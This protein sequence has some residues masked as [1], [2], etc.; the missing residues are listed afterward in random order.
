MRRTVKFTKR[1]GNCLF[2]RMADRKG[3]KSYNTIEKSQRSIWR[4]WIRLE[5]L[6]KAIP[7]RRWLFPLT[8]QGT[9]QR[10]WISSISHKLVNWRSILEAE[11]SRK[12][13]QKRR[14]KAKKDKRKWGSTQGPF[15]TWRVWTNANHWCHRTVSDRLVSGLTLLRL[16]SWNSELSGRL[17]SWH[18]FSI[19]GRRKDDQ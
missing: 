10:T 17:R 15:V 8:S 19:C 2:W 3:L 9:S 13:T 6:G 11:E 4:K 12:I 5:L 18:L 7:R 14:R 1:Q 16:S